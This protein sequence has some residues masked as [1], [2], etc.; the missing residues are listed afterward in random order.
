MLKN[1]EAFFPKN[2][3]K[4][5]HTSSKE[6]LSTVEKKFHNARNNAIICYQC[7]PHTYTYY[8]KSTMS[9]GFSFRIP[10]HLFSTGHN[11][12]SYPTYRKVKNRQDG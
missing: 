12:L 3:T 1:R 6:P 7:I 9:T 11:L 4:F 5:A 2:S 10:P 8:E